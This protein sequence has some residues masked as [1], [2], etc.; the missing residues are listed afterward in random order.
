MTMTVPSG[1]KYL[2]LL[3]ASAGSKERIRSALPK[4]MSGEQ[5]SLPMRTWLVTEPPRCAIPMVSAECTVLPSS[6]AAA[7]MILLASTVP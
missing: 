1:F 7:A 5:A 6:M 3:T 4:G 2:R